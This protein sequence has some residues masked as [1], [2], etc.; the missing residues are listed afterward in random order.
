MNSARFDSVER[1]HQAGAPL[2][3]GMANPNRMQNADHARKMQPGSEQTNK[4]AASE[5]EAA[6]CSIMTRKEE[7]SLSLAGLAATYSPRA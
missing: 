4:N 5:M 2:G 1:D 7:I 3:H 6:F